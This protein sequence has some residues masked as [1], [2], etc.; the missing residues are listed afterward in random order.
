MRPQC[1]FTPFLFGVT[2]GSKETPEG[3]K[4]EHRTIVAL[5]DTE[6][7]KCKKNV[8]RYSTEKG[9]GKSLLLYIPAAS[10][11]IINEFSLQL[12]STRANAGAAGYRAPQ[13][14]EDVLGS[15]Y[16]SISGA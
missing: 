14:Q 16:S 3:S 1:T 9:T 5:E 12:S 13:T 6:Y 11:Y 10:S 2:P 4:I 15:I 8:F 7:V